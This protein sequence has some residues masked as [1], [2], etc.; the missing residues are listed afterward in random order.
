[1]LINII[2]FWLLIL[3]ISCYYI[4]VLLY[5]FF[6]PSPLLFFSFGLQ[7]AYCW[8]PSE[9]LGLASPQKWQLLGPAC[10]H[11]WSDVTSFTTEIYLH[12]PLGTESC[13]LLRIHLQRCR[14]PQCIYLSSASCPTLS[15]ASALT[16]WV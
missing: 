12:L 9:K 16:C 7:I 3:I 5:Y 14:F 4:H 6:L 8:F 10:C 11:S 15:H 13:V 2:F 1:M